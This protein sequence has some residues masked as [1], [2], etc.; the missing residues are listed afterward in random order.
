[1]A[2]PVPK[3]TPAKPEGVAPAA[4][5]S[6]SGA[7][8]MLPAELGEF[9]PRDER[10]S[11]SDLTKLSLFRTEE[12][13]KDKN[14]PNFTKFSGTSVLR[15]YAAGDVICR[16]GDAGASAFSILTTEDVLALREHQLAELQAAPGEDKAGNQDRKL[17]DFRE[18]TPEQRIEAL[19]S[20]IAAFKQR[21]ASF[22]APGPELDRARAAA[23]VLLTPN[24]E[25]PQKKKSGIAG[26]FSSL[27]G[28][29]S[30]AVPVSA[31]KSIAIDAPVGLQSKNQFRATLHEGQLFGEMSC[32]NRSPRSATV[33]ADRDCY[34]LEFLR[35][36]LDMLHKDPL[37]KARIDA[38]YRKRVLETD[39]RRLQYFGEAFDRLDEQEFLEIQKRIELV[40]F[41]AGSVVMEEGAE[42]DAVY[43]I[44]S[45]LAKIIKNGGYTLHGKDFDDGRWSSLIGELAAVESADNPLAS[46]L[47]QALPAAVK[48]LLKPDAGRDPAVREQILGALNGL[49]HQGQ[50]LALKVKVDTKTAKTL[51]ELLELI[52]NAQVTESFAPFPQAIDSWSEYE[53]RVFGRGLLEVLCPRGIPARLD[54]YGPPVILNYLGRGEVLGEMGLLTN[55]PRG[56]TVVAYDHPDGYNQRVPDSR[57]GA[58]PSRIELIKIGRDLFNELLGKFPELRE[59][60]NVIATE[61]AGMNQSLAAP[62]AGV[63]GARGMLGDDFERLGLVQGQRLMLIDL[64]RCTRC[65]ACV[66]ACVES[67]NDGFSRLYL[68]GM[69]F[70]KYLIPLTCRSC[71]DPVCM[72]GCPVGSIQRGSNLQIKI[73]NWCIGCA[74]CADQCPY[75]SIQLNPIEKIELSTEQQRALPAGVN[76]KQV[77]S[78]AVVCDLCSS[79]A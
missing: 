24:L 19:T 12:F 4:A 2:P 49:I 46:A 6:S 9:G 17:P 58:V 67:H 39:V 16:Q 29:G 45:G 71:L 18:E 43:I 10:L 25:T 32:L 51:D 34:M 3:T 36:V 74:M 52:E 14:I 69:R 48:G 28:G 21:I 41:P 38:D 77:E 54:L 53:G 50:S 55:Q 22:P 15:R 20:E 40:E 5:K 31:P 60:L 75:G 26:F 57:M 33:I 62:T 37:Y 47:W 59:R 65:G 70:D 11:A 1:M 56:A 30:S 72:I 64:D 8:A 78:R 27:F 63:G 66:E 44:R 79:T 42:S 68:D 61:R 35:N 7:E 76:L 13:E 73:E 23:T